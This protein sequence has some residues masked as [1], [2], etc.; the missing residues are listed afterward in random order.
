MKCAETHRN[1]KTSELTF[2]TFLLFSFLWG[3]RLLTDHSLLS[4]QIEYKH[5][6]INFIRY[7]YI[8]FGKLI[9]PKIEMKWKGWNS[10]FNDTILMFYYCISLI[11][12]LR[13]YDVLLFFCSCREVG[14]WIDW[15]WGFVES[16]KGIIAFFRENIR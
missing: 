3:P 10:R 16:L 8:H 14:G 2:Y 7:I 1:K 12:M 15:E 6:L 11:L 13:I 5:K 4:I 9:S